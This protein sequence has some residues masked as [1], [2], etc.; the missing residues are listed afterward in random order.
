MHLDNQIKLLFPKTSSFMEKLMNILLK[1]E[2]NKLLNAISAN[3]MK[4]LK[5]IQSSICTE[6]IIFHLVF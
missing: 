6:K 4:I 3:I 1:I 2:E 5:K